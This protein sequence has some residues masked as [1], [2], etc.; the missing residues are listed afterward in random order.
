MTVEELH[1]LQITAPDEAVRKQVQTNWDNI[2]KPLNGL[3][4]FEGLLA[5]I[6]AIQGT[7]RIDIRKK[8]VVVMCADN[9][10][11][12]EGISQ[13]GQE[14]TAIIASAM[15][16]RKS[17]VCKMAQS[18]GAEVIPV[19][20][21]INSK[22][23]IPGVLDKKVAR[24]TRNF[25]KEPAMTMEETLKAIG[26]G[27]QTAEECKKAGYRLLV[28]G[29]MGIGNTT[30]SSAVA[31]ALLGCRAEA[32]TGRGAGLSDKGLAR[33]KQVIEAALLKY[34]LPVADTLSILA[35]LGGLDIAALTGVFIGGALYGLPIVID[36][37]ISAV[38]AL[39]AVR[40]LPGV[41]AYLIP[42]HMSKE[43]AMERIMQELSLAPVIDGNLAL[44]E[45]TGG[46]MMCTLLDMALSLYESK[47]TFSEVSMEQYEHFQEKEAG[48]CLC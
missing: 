45:G 28:T 48:T 9:G 18:I 30:T 36:G 2:A 1:S 7:D 10:V 5:Q 33:K 46:V 25:A 35:T 37:V 32:V 14:V 39:A 38:A 17:S 27:M 41:R 13:S 8:A 40:L 6:G 19:D 15:G 29:E 20:V 31:A 23:P 34:S 21:G 42:S 12:A 24:G 22:E 11:V 26:V 4:R 43:T 47:T 16:Q 44:G 3:G